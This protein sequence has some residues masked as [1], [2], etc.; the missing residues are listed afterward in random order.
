VAGG[1][2]DWLEMR[3]EPDKA[4][5]AAHWTYPYMGRPKRKWGCGGRCLTVRS[6]D[7]D[8]HIRPRRP[9]CPW[10]RLR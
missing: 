5:K 10:T 7:G 6:W 3:E 9:P 2:H 8:S 4:N 1:Y